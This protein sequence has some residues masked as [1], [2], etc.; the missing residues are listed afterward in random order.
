MNF[1]ICLAL[2]IQTDNLAE[3]QK[4]IT[5]S[6]ETSPDLIELRLD[7]LKDG[8]SINDNF[9]NALFKLI[10]SKIP[11]IATLRDNNEGGHL[12]LDID[13]KTKII[14]DLISFKPD[15]LDIEMKTESNLITTIIKTAQQN[16]V[17]LIFSYH[18]F[19]ETPD[20]KE[21]LDFVQKF[22]KQYQISRESIVKLI[23][24]AQKFEDNFI[25]LELCKRL[26]TVKIISF[27]MGEIGLLSRIMSAKLGSLWTYGSLSELTAPGQISIE[28][29]R[30]IY[31]LLFNSD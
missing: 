24:M 3:N 19:T 27:C 8:E 25:P 21:I 4:L 12:F 18:N 30:K 7:Y 10:P 13:N 14:L 17:K 28:K 6:L 31:Q 20:L 29:I 22:Q 9:I 2:P 11:I 15:F 16:N 5:R 26:E 1:K 23:F